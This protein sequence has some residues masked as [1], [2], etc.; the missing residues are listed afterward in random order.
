MSR[1]LK[2]FFTILVAALAVI[3]TPVKSGTKQA[4]LGCGPEFSVI[5]SWSTESGNSTLSSA[6]TVA[7]TP[8]AVGHY[9]EETNGGRFSPLIERWN[10]EKMVLVPAPAPGLGGWL[11]TVSGSSPK[12]VLF[13]G[14]YYKAPPAKRTSG[15]SGEARSQD[16]PLA[17][18]IMKYNGRKVAVISSPSLGKARTEIFDVK[19]F[20]E[21]SFFVGFY[22]D[23]MEKGY[24]SRAF[25]FRFDG[26]RVTSIPLPVEWGSALFA[27][28]G[29]SPNDV[30]AVGFARN[31]SLVIH[32]DGKTAIRASSPSP[33]PVENV[34]RDVALPSPGI[35]L[36]T[37]YSVYD[38]SVWR[39]RVPLNF[40]W[41]R[42]DGTWTVYD[43]ANS[44][45]QARPGS[46][47]VAI[48]ENEVWVLSDKGSLVR[49]QTF[50]D[51]W[52]QAK[53]KEFPFISRYYGLASV[54]GRQ[55]W[56]V[57]HRARKAAVETL[58]IRACPSFLQ[59]SPTTG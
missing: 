57:G 28:G 34:L 5:S 52:V 12:S 36:M 10:G 43:V 55:V 47:M 58:V 6:A 32:W 18:L 42:S 22:Q 44:R 37:G 26:R 15:K 4:P 1:R 19:D 14:A 51:K 24:P 3:A 48:S 31:E 49:T 56:L 39:G 23:S 11:N 9:M 54:S 17:A 45:D 21:I 40:R 20:G 35:A 25:M 41:N 8:W 50:P 33:G 16:N 53:P 38:S 46:A 30:V 29:S 59:L 13:G 7:G 2:W 27:V